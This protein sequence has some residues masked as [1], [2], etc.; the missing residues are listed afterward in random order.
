MRGAGCRKIRSKSRVDHN[1]QKRRAT[2][3]VRCVENFTLIL[4][5][6]CRRMTA[7]ACDVHTRA[8]VRD[9]RWCRPHKSRHKIR[10]SESRADIL[11]P[12]CHFHFKTF[13]IFR[14][15]TFLFTKI[16]TESAPNLGLKKHEFLTRSFCNVLRRARVANGNCFC[17]RDQ[18]QS[19]S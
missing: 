4:K 16:L 17:G 6:H 12:G 15:L 10:T 14:H 9:L 7:R 13:K 1:R 18:P 19:H 5:V 3:G 2:G 8:N 11:A